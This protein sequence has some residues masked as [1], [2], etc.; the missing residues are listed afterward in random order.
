[1]KKPEWADLLISQ[2]LFYKGRKTPP[3]IKWVKRNRQ[4]SSGVM[5]TRTKNITICVGHNEADAKMVVLHELSHWLLTKGHHH[6]IKFWVTAWELYYLF[7]EQLDWELV[8]RR[9]FA[10]MGKAKVVYQRLGY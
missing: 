4:S 1:M 10:Y 8:K 2:V 3:K 5:Y 9:E 6:D 7:K